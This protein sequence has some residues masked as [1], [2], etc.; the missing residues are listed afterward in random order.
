MASPLNQEEDGIPPNIP[1]ITPPDALRPF[2]RSPHPYHRKSASTSKPSEPSAAEQRPSSSS[3]HLAPPRWSRTS[4][5][6]G[7]EADD[8]S[9]G[10][11]KGLPA[12]P[13]R[14]RKGLRAEDA[15]DPWLSALPFLARAIARR[16][17]R[18]S[19][20][21]TGTGTGTGTGNGNKL[22]KARGRLNR[23]KRVEVLRRLLEVALLVSVGAVVVRPEDVRSLAWAW[24]KGMIYL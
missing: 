24:R 22:T 19:G 4:S 5:D 8:E 17:P 15:E 12:P 1:T 7:T 2:S 20:E 3:T 21:E 18:G 11:L 14:P 23:E 6:S 9:T 10:I 16:S 13:V